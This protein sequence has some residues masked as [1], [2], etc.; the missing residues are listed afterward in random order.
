MK[1]GSGD[2]AQKSFWL[3]GK[4]GKRGKWEIYAHYQLTSPSLKYHFSL[5]LPYIKRQFLCKF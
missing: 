1:I 5:A 4:K 2:W 3:V